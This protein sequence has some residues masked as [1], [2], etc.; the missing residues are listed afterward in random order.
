MKKLVK[1]FKNFQKRNYISP[2]HLEL[3]NEIDKQ[4]NPLYTPE[5]QKPQ[6][7]IYDGKEII[8][9]AYVLNR[10]PVITKH[11]HPIL[12]EA[13]AVT[14]ENNKIKTSKKYLNFHDYY[15]KWKEEKGKKDKVN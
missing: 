4:K 14:N 15:I 12:M 7:V 2:L 10:L 8:R 9:V 6:P 13:S 5:N 1:N 11:L 3:G